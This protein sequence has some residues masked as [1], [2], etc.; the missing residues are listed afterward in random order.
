[1]THGH[2]SRHDIFVTNPR[3][4]LPALLATTGLTVFALIA[5]TL[6]RPKGAPPNLVLI[7][8]DTTRADRIGAYGYG[9]AR[10]PALDALAREGVL[11]EQAMAAAPLTLPAHG[12]IFT[13]SFPPSHGVR[14]NGGF[15]LDPAQ[16]TLAEVLKTAGVQT[17]AAVGAY[18]LD[19]KWG[20]DQGF[21]R[22]ADDFDLSNIRG[23]S[24]A[25]VQRPGNE[26]VDKALAWLDTARTQ[27]FFSWIHLYDPH[28]PYDPPEPFKSDFAGRPYDGE[29]AFVDAQVG[30]VIEYLRRHDL[31]EQT[32]I[33]VIGDHGEGL[34][35]HGESAHGFFIYESSTHV[36]FIV[37]VPRAAGM[38]GRR[39]A[40]PV[41]AVDLMP[42]VLDL[43]GVQVPAGLAGTS[44]VPLMSG[45]A[46]TLDL[47][48][49][50]E[51]LYPLH[52][53]GWSDLKALRAGRYKLID[54]PRP[55]LYD[56]SE[57]PGEE[58]N[59]FE[60]RRALGDTMMARLRALDAEFARQTAPAGPTA[61]VDPEVR[62][63]L[64]ALG[65]VGSFVAT[66]ATPRTG[67]ADPK[68]KIEIFNLMTTA[69]DAS[70]DGGDAS[71]DVVRMLESV[72]ASDPEVIDA[73]FMLGNEFYKA[74][75]YDTA[76][77]HF[78]KALEL[79]PDYDLAIINL[80]NCYRAL[81][82]DD[83]A[84][85]GYE[86]YLTVDPKNAYV[87]YQV[88]EIYL[89]RGDIGA[90]EKRFQKALE[91]DAS[92]A[93]ARNALGVVA[94]KRGQLDAAEREINAAIALKADVRLAHYNL[95]LIAE[96]RND[97]P[98][99]EAEYKR[100]VELHP[101]AFKASF[102][103]GRLYE[104]LGRVSDQVAALKQSIDANPDFAEG[105]F[106]LA[107]A[108]LDAN[109]N[110][111]D[112]LRL[113]RRGLELAPISEMAPLGH[114]VIAGVLM[115]RGK[116]DAATREFEAGRALEARLARPGR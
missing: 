37:R 26:V 69:R 9:P 79:K 60:E 65:Y 49:Y 48:G 51:A 62:S 105:H 44:L 101:S 29:I 11:F 70:K 82:K 73:W 52:H 76:I 1:L 102:N 38:Q 42:T 98:R 78:K 81:D 83:A 61:D 91:I 57:D 93:A 24:L 25:T 13:G 110:L 3:R 35:Q 31:L 111:D 64:A 4:W 6:W 12:S 99:A 100:E 18:V 88:G 14:D 72:V 19:S 115:K 22:Y 86:H 10:T 46:A 43:L 71:T 77:T 32:V 17:G 92:V 80:A 75:R 59:V 107:K 67:R 23:M 68:D 109:A 15:F 53:F 66:A 116:P 34:G 74:R 103:L 56:L 2:S 41:R 108:Y 39:I 28:T 95:A 97:F 113:A 40:D 55:E 27:R 50:A 84:L 89:D 30:R 114:F 47:E 7:T 33:A 16:T 54:A 94:H 58:R 85:A 20:M 36:P 106:F 90:A 45:R 104:R 112:A 87:W 5:I 63:R 96:E 21:D 8:L